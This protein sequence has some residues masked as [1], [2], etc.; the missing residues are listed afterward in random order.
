MEFQFGLV[1]NWKML[2]LQKVLMKSNV[3]LSNGVFFGDFIF[4]IT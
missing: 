3:L 2:V 1:S 4:S